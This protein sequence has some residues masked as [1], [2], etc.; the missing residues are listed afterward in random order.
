MSDFNQVLHGKPNSVW[1][2]A[3]RL[4]FKIECQKRSSDNMPP[5]DKK[6]KVTLYAFSSL[7][8]H[9]KYKLKKISNFMKFF[10]KIAFEQN[11]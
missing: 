1:L 11:I 4:N 6:I 10:V 8:L 9:S 2:E 5:E 7:V 3:E